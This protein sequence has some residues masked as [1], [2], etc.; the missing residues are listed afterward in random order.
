MCERFEPRGNVK[1]G[2]SLIVRVNVVLNRTVIVDSRVIRD[3][4]IQRRGRQRE[5]QKTNKQTN[6]KQ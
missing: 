2:L 5:R 3:F 4:K 1:S 6:K